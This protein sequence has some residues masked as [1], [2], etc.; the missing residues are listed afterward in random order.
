MWVSA[1]EARKA[2]EGRHMLRVRDT[3]R[4]D[5]EVGQVDTLVQSCRARETLGTLKIQLP[6]DQRDGCVC[7]SLLWRAASSW[8]ETFESSLGSS[9]LSPFFQ[10]WYRRASVYVR[11]C[12][13]GKEGRGK[14][15]V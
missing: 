11:H 2:A 7:L 3:H 5:I 14:G 15:V 9:K 8:R 13:T 12:C 1:V 4:F 10:K 6:R